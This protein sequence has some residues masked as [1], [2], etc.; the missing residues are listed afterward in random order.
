MQRGI[1]VPNSAIPE[2]SCGRIILFTRSVFPRPAQE[3]GSSMQATAIVIRYI[4]VRM[5][6]D[7]FA[8][9]DGGTLDFFNRAINF[10]DGF[11]FMR[12]DGSITWS[13]F[14]HPS[15]RSHVSKTM[16]IEG[17]LAR[18]GSTP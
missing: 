5:V 16:K 14:E 15:S 10:A 4:D 9:I 17:V 6:V 1:D 12:A 8:I 13:M 2:T 3:F 18:L 7:I 11:I